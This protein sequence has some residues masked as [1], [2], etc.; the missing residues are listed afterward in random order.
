MIRTAT[1]IALLALTACVG[2]PPRNKREA[3]AHCLDNNYSRSAID[4]AEAVDRIYSEG[5]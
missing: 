3:F 2:D 1:L 5:K 4:C